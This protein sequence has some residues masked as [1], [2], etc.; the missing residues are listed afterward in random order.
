MHQRSLF[1]DPVVDMRETQHRKY[2]AILATG[3]AAVV[4]SVARTLSQPFRLNDLSVACHR[5]DPDFFGMEG[6]KHH[7]DNHKIHSFLY[8]RR[9]LI[10][11]G[12]L[13]RIDEG[14]F[15]VPTPGIPSHHE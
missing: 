13:E 15:R 7:P 11:R 4:L 5:H 10:R 1:D 6:Y 3:K 2:E 12:H 9:G 8:G 14:L